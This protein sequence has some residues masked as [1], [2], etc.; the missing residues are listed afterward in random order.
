MKRTTLRVSLNT[1]GVFFREG[2]APAEPRRDDSVTL[3]STRSPAG[4]D[5][6]DPVEQTGPASS[7]CGSAGASPSRPMR[8][9]KGRVSGQTRTTASAIRAGFSLMEVILATAILL[10]S[11]IVL[12]ELAG[13]G[14]RQSLR[15]RDL[16]EAQQLCEMTL[17]EILA[18]LRPLE[19]QEQEPLL[20]EQPLSTAA[21]GGEAYAEPY[22]EPTEGLDPFA[23]DE[24]SDLSEV[25][26]G[27][28]NLAD[29]RWFHSIRIT[30]LE[31]QPGLAVL[32]V[33]IEQ[34]P[35]PVGRP[36]RFQLSRWIDDPFA[37]EAGESSDGPQPV[38]M[39]SRGGRTP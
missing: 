36:V 30:P 19:P 38:E 2:E 4:A 12:G 18:G 33:S 7:A 29:V 21:A 25:E 31:E 11:V 15:G 5:P 28:E 22:V 9:F 3:V 35:P 24:E 6:R 26:P 32:T 39:V 1:D 23:F 37:E 17:N 10:G 20:F 13:M 34:A 27:G 8:R 14:R 16:A